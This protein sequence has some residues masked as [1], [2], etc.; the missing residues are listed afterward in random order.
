MEDFVFFPRQNGSGLWDSP[1]GLERD[2]EKQANIL[3]YG[4]DL[5]LLETRSWVLEGAG[6]RAQVAA[7]FED[8]MRIFET[9]SPD[10]TILCHSLPPEQRA[11]VLDATRV[12]RPK[13]KML[14]L[15]GGLEPFRGDEETAVIDSFDGPR[16]LLATVERLLARPGA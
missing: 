9:E 4:R 12:I 2:V 1:P 7:N 3:V 13:R 15:V 14:V 8:A 5:S 10:L 6:F 11:T 16:V